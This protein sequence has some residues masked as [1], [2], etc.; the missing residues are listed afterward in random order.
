MSES[1][2]KTVLVTGAN[3][4]IGTRL[5]QAL[6]ERGYRI[7]AVVRN[8]NRLR[9]ELVDSLGGQLEII[10]A[11]FSVE[12]LPQISEKVDAAYYLL[13]SM[14]S[15]GDFMDAE[16]ECANHFASWIRGSGC[17]QIVYLGALLPQD[18]EGTVLSKHMK[19]RE[20]VQ[21]ILEGSMVPL[22]TLRASIIV[23]SGSASFEI[24][25]DLVE[26]LPVM[27]TPKWASTEC[28]PIAI[29]NIIYYLVGVIESEVCKGE[30]YDVGGP[31]Q[32]SYGDM[33][34]SYA[35]IRKLTRLIIPVPFFS[36]KLSSHWLQLFTATN[37]HLAK[38]LIDS[39]SMKT[40]CGDDRITEVIPQTLLTYDEA[41]D[42]AFSKIAQ[43]MVPSTWYGSLVSGSLTHEQLANV[44]V[45]EHGVFKDDRSREITVSKDECIDAI[46]SLGGRAGWPS[47][48]WAWKIR[49]VMDKMVG[50][51]GMR[52]GRRHPSELSAGDAL[53][54][55]RVIL[56]DRKRGRLIL[57][58]EM[59]LPGEAWL[60]YEVDG[61]RLH[62]VATFRPKGVFGR[63]YWY[64]VYPLHLI[65]FPQM[66]RR[67]AS[68]WKNRES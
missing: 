35:K 32:L 40:V 49:G 30:D 2:E 42:K 28:Q 43:N 47:M 39:L 52:R 29:R 12:E 50:G 65:I 17:G 1:I 34:R 18:V 64:A 23:G 13:H 9:Q 63:V 59:K 3:G 68:G 15:E 41:I 62:Q 22:T 58:A 10:E 38:N 5:I 67:L 45:P 14:S 20:N 55:W 27:I 51:I 25:R 56:A 44:N 6:G 61:D 54:F 21:R 19:S 46:W 24:I 8:R 33:L 4:Y 60:E 57:Y 36:A 31:E 11:D 16:A 48:Q 26:K 37:F 53:D 7:L 66:L